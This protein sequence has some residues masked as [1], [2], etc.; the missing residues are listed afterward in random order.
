MSQ[1]STAIWDS[2]LSIGSAAGVALMGQ[3]KGKYIFFGHLKWS[4]AIALGY[5]ASILI[6]MWTNTDLLQLTVETAR[7][8]TGH[9]RNSRRVSIGAHVR[10]LTHANRSYSDDADSRNRDTD[11]N[12]A[13]LW[14]KSRVRNRKGGTHLNRL[15]QP[16]PLHSS[17]QHHSESITIAPSSCMLSTMMRYFLKH[18]D[19][20]N[21]LFK[22]CNKNSLL[23]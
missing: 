3:A 19:T 8:T 1:A 14:I 5:V 12:R 17:T 11:F 20:W 6:H 22:N 4:W 10:E 18:P 23:Q 13:N 21:H 16:L 7:I 9:W 15:S 2:L